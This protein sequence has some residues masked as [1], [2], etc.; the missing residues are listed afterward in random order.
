MTQVSGRMQLD[1][2]HRCRRADQDDAA[3]AQRGWPSHKMGIDAWWLDALLAL[4]PRASSVS[5]PLMGPYGLLDHLTA[6]LVLTRATLE[7]RAPS[8]SR[9]CGIVPVCA[10]VARHRAVLPDLCGAVNARR[11]SFPQGREARVA[12]SAQHATRHGRGRAARLIAG[13]RAAV[14]E[15]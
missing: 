4:Q 10:A 9:C 7:Q 1:G 6:G 12:H 11:Q 15:H 14:G 3:F 5:P 8:A 2:N 13:P